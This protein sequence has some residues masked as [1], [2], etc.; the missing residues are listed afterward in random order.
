MS[1]EHFFVPGLFVR[2]KWLSQKIDLRSQR[3]NLWC[4]LYF[5][6]LMNSVS[7][8][9]F[10]CTNGGNE[11]YFWLEKTLTLKKLY[12]EENSNYPKI[13]P[14]ISKLYTADLGAFL[15]VTLV[16]IFYMPN[17]MSL[18]LFCFTFRQSQRSKVQDIQRSKK[19]M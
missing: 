13:T 3:Q 19:P 4:T 1:C 6:F 16:S 10:Y 17:I 11:I 18:F 5:Y 15:R 14:Q 7:F 8:S 9:L 12:L 2:K